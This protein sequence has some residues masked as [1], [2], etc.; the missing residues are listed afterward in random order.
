VH[1]K[2]KYN[3]QTHRSNLPKGTEAESLD[4]LSHTHSMVLVEARGSELKPYTAYP[5]TELSWK[6]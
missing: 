5:K 1:R 2:E 3:S 4:E 6:R